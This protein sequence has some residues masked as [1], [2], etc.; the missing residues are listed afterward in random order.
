MTNY[1][2][3][4]SISF[5]TLVFCGLTSYQMNYFILTD[6]FLIVKNSIWLW[7][8]DIYSLEN[9]R[10]IVFEKPNRLSISMRVITKDFKSKL[11]P[12]D[13]LKNKTWKQLREKIKSNQIKVRNEANV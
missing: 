3:L 9:I 5:M 8:K 4:L 2:A 6:N 13:S 12:S 10:E 11:Y 1:G 7:Q